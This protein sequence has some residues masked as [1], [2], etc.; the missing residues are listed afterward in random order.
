MKILIIMYLILILI[1]AVI[2]KCS[3]TDMQ[4]DGTI[5]QIKYSSLDTMQR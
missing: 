1:N 4:I 5:W 2:K 3:D